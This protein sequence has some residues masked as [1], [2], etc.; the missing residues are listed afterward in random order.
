VESL[1]CYTGESLHFKGLLLREERY[2]RR[3]AGLFRTVDNMVSLKEIENRLNFL[4]KKT[5]MHQVLHHLPSHSCL[6]QLFICKDHVQP[7]AALATAPA[8]SEKKMLFSI[9]S[10]WPVVHWPAS[11]SLFFHIC[12]SFGDNSSHRL[13]SGCSSTAA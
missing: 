3:E 8:T 6:A 2:S 13:V 1:V 5:S 10:P 4:R 7:K 12:C 9:V 11:T